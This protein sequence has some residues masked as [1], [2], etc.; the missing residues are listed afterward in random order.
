MHTQTLVNFFQENDTLPAINSKIL[1][2]EGNAKTRIEMVERYAKDHNVT[3]SVQEDATI[4]SAVSD[5]TGV[6]AHPRYIEQFKSFT[7]RFDN[8][9]SLFHTVRDGIYDYYKVVNGEFNG[10]MGT[11]K[12]KELSMY[13][14]EWG[15]ME[16]IKEYKNGSFVYKVTPEFA[17]YLQ[18]VLW[19]KRFF[20]SKGTW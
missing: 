1:I 18:R 7:A 2:A 6:Y 12:S 9:H 4:A 13:G 5:V 17:E 15:T 16:V 20:E 11:F 19:I 14:T 10:E 8:W 3:V